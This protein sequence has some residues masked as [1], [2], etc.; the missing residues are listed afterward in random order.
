LLA[1]VF[2]H[3]HRIRGF[4]MCPFLPVHLQLVT[5]HRALDLPVHSFGLHLAE[6]DSQVWCKVLAGQF[7]H[8]HVATTV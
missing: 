4:Y 6:P 7:H 2:Y 1:S 5:N 8:C 3:D